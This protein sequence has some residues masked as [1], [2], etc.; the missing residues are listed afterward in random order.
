MG[1]GADMGV[2]VGR[3]ACVG[4]GEREGL[5]TAVSVGVAVALLREVGAS[6]GADVDSE[7][8]RESGAAR[9]GP[10][11]S[12]DTS[13]GKEVEV[14]LCSFNDVAPRQKNLSSPAL[15][16]EGG[17]IPST[18]DPSLL[19]FRPW[20]TSTLKGQLVRGR[21]FGLGQNVRPEVSS[22]GFSGQRSIGSIPSSRCFGGIVAPGET[23]CVPLCSSGFTS[24]ALGK[25][26]RGDD[27]D[28][29]RRRPPRRGDEKVA[30][31]STT[32]CRR[33]P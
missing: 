24:E 3:G 19:V 23:V 33:K 4:A 16:G 2:C 29:R 22:G 25:R 7:V 14:F 8:S 18:T 11:A 28:A 31:S 26:S 13:I 30:P 17:R 12:V 6:S 21:R 15:V 27:A 1:K 32:S 9:G 10:A 20:C 5:L